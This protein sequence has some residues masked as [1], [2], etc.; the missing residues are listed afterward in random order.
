MT[1]LHNFENVFKKQ[2]TPLLGT[3]TVELAPIDGN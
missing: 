1:T 2:F 3:F